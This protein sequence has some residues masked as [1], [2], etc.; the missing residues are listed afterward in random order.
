M[1]LQEAEIADKFKK[2]VGCW[3]T[4]TPFWSFHPFR[5]ENSKKKD[6]FRTCERSAKVSTLR[7]S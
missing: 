4:D 6:Y 1:T 2:S 5:V 3:A 7:P